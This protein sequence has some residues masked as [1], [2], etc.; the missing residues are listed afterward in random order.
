MPSPKILTSCCVF[1]KHRR[2]TFVL[3]MEGS[4]VKRGTDAQ[5]M[6]GADEWDCLTRNEQC[7]EVE[8][9]K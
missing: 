7:C 2:R 3:S 9:L 6:T 1:W 5:N 4:G 8:R